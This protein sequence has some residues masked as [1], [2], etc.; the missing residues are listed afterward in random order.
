MQT[1]WC[2]EVE[3]APLHGKLLVIYNVLDDDW[4][5][6]FEPLITVRLGFRVF[7]TGHALTRSGAISRAE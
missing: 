5:D 4:Y 6:D 3:R 1:R 2:G 7:G